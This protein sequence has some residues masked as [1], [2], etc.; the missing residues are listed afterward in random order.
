MSSAA[1]RI[2]VKVLNG[3]WYTAAAVI[4]L[5]ALLVSVGREFLP[6]IEITDPAVLN[7]IN[8]K[9]GGEIQIKRLRSE[10]TTLYP[11]FMVDQ[12]VVVHDNI[13][14]ELNQ[15]R[16]Q[17]N[18]LQT[19]LKQLPVFNHLS[20]QQAKIA[21]ISSGKQ[22]PLDTGKLYHTLYTILGD[23]IHVHEAWLSFQRDQ[24]PAQHLRL[25]QLKITDSFFS[26]TVAGDVYLDAASR[27]N[28]LVFIA[29]ISGS[30]LNSASGKAYL[31][32]QQLMISRFTQQFTQTQWQDWLQQPWYGDAEIWLNWQG[33]REL[34]STISAAVARDETKAAVP[35][36]AAVIGA[37]KWQQKSGFDISLNELRV[38]K[39]AKTEWQAIIKQ[40]S[41]TFTD[42][43][44]VS[45]DADH[46]DLSQLNNL[47]GY[48]P[49][50]KL[51]DTLT[52]LNPKGSL[53][54]VQLRW[55]SQKNLRERMH[56]SARADNLSNGSWTGVPAFTGVSGTIQSGLLDG[57]I[58][59]NSHN[60]FSMHFAKLYDAPLAF[61]TAE[62]FVQWQ[63][64][65][66]A[67][68]LYI[69]SSE[70][71]MTGEMG[72]AVGAF[73]L[74]IPLKNASVDGDLTL[75]IGLTDTHSRYH[76]QLVPTVLPANLRK[77]LA[78][79]IHDGIIPKAGF[80]YRGELSNNT[81]VTRTSQVYLDVNKARLHFDPNWPEVSDVDAQVI[82][83]DSTVSVYATQGKLLQ[84]TI[85]DTEI[86]ISQIEPGMLIE[87]TGDAAG[88][89]Q[90]LIKILTDTPLK[91]SAGKVFSN[92]QVDAGSA[93]GRI[94]LGIAIGSNVE[95]W[96]HVDLTLTD[97][98]VAMKDLNLKLLDVSGPLTF[99]SEQGLTSESLAGQIFG[100]PVT[101][102]IRTEL[103]NNTQQFIVDA[104]TKAR[105]DDLAR[106]TKLQPLLMAKGSLNA[107]LQLLFNG[108]KG[109]KIGEIHAK[110][111]MQGVSLDLPAPLAKASDAK[112]PLD[113]NIELFSDEQRYYFDYDNI[114][115]GA[116]RLVGGE[117]H[118]GQIA[119][120]QAASLPAQASPLLIK[121]K[122]PQVDLNAWL[123]VISHFAKLPPVST[124]SSSA[125]ASASTTPMPMPV[126]AINS[127]TVFWGEFALNDVTSNIRQHN[128]GWQIDIQSPDITG[129]V[130]YPPQASTPIEVN[131]QQL[132]Y[133]HTPAATAAT[134]SSSPASAKTSSNNIDFSKIPAL[135][136]H[137]DDFI[138]NGKTVARG[139]A[140]LR[141]TAREL[142]L[143]KIMIDGEGYQIR[144]QGIGVDDGATLKWSKTASG[145][146]TNL[147]GRVFLQ[148]PQPVISH[149]GFDPFITGEEINLI[150]N[151]KWPAAPQDF[152]LESLQGELFT[153]GKNGQFTKMNHNPALQ[154]LNVLDINN[155]VRR[156]RL[157][158]SDLTSDKIPFE[159][160]KGKITF[161][162]SFL[163]L[164]EPVVIDGSSYVITL[165]G[166][167]NLQSN[168]LDLQLAAT[169]PVA[170]NAA[171][172]AGLAA[173]LP[174]AAGLYVASKVFNFDEHLK[175]LTSLI[176]AITGP[177]SEPDVQFKGMAAPPKKEK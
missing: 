78:D 3:L 50:G 147:H 176:Y 85:R 74:E 54:Q 94:D 137:I 25:E 138:Y 46:I 165:G 141:S 119:I 13:D 33:T 36:G 133:N 58:K 82:V 175:G 149:L 68:A 62:G 76:K 100:Q 171:W 31:R 153:L 14:I 77:W 88:P 117:L 166:R 156:M 28:R 172:I 143:N 22:T 6:Q 52:A 45:F 152:S 121:A 157:D 142:I 89:A 83:D 155:W 151:V 64:Q 86:A 7:K 47:I 80:F 120:N 114:A 18:I 170:T 129:Q 134:A 11:T 2:L 104:R 169:L 59:L 1:N 26:K 160:L 136:I 71:V 116:I 126:F 8:E 51:K 150:A 139:S 101:A 19:A 38:K 163:R 107:E 29:E 173:G 10:W 164:S 73:Q 56:I 168:Q 177:L 42:Q 118:A 32:A 37:L 34:S 48:V 122:L 70:A 72:R 140:Q 24:Q 41:A 135:N 110:S 92:W 102:K 69:G 87:V 131:I 148:G 66:I 17:L 106:W 97:I 154:I 40:W 20:V 9:I 128:R 16:F 146:Q 57:F 21:A 159:T 61:K 15:L 95:S 105:I 55:D 53:R 90:Q 75:A 109:N 81:D 63:W 35:Y 123:D 99:S 4:L 12:V 39:D 91:D 161:K 125:S 158:F 67:N 79:N 23:N 60:G 144:H 93:A 162:D 115:E 145:Q 127:P 130:W 5:V 96:Q 124:Q 49:A 65:P 108:F 44:R 112:A 27:D 167:V 98:D 174:A 43:G 84:S 111:D 132:R 103:V 113:L 30:D